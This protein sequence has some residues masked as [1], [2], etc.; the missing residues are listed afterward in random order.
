MYQGLYHTVGGVPNGRAGPSAAGGVRS[1]P[2]DGPAGDENTPIAA[3][4][5]APRLPLRP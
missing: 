5:T 1:A 3:G 2:G 4:N